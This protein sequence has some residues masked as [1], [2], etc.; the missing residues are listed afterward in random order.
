MGI[1]EIHNKLSV[2]L[3][4]LVVFLI[5]LTGCHSY[6]LDDA[7]T[8]LRSSFADGEFKESAHL[9][10]TFED[11]E[12]YRSNDEV[13]WNL[14][15]GMVAHFN[16]DFDASTRYL[17]RAEEQIDDAFTKSISR[18]VY[19]MVSN[20]NVLVYDG[21]PYED[22]Y[23]NAF[24]ALN[25]IHQKNWEGALVETRR[26]AYKMEQLDIRIKGIAEA[27]ARA[28]TTG[29][30]SWESGN[31]NIQN[32]AMSHYLAAILYAKSGRP[33]DSRI[34]FEKLGIA[35][36]E[37]AQLSGYS[38]FDIS[39]MESI[40]RP[41]SYNLLIA[42]FTGQ[43]PLKYQVDVRL[44][45]DLSEG[46]YLKFSFPGIRLYPTKVNAVRAVVNDS[47]E[48]PL[49]LVEEMDLVAQEVYK[50]KEPV[51][52]SRALLRA[53]LKAG[54]TNFVQNMAKEKSE[55]A[56]FITSLLSVLFKEA[57]EKADL[58]GWQTLPGQ[59]WMNVI[60]LPEG[61]NTVRLEYLSQQNKV[62]YFE[63]Y[64]VEMNSKTSLELIESIYSK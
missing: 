42:G 58:R 26:M 6:M 56:G 27:F 22:I 13:L 16:G 48:I 18:G 49:H 29:K 20:D 63:E 25:F 47:L 2:N 55:T 38:P 7:Q 11:K 30:V 62:L 3:L 37:Q 21:E 54:G 14:E 61:P 33:D 31:V 35:L 34:E 43:A 40:T 52:Y 60:E 5:S 36:Q 19:S 1:P 57:S 51:I 44:I 9:L 8:D 12:L 17:S 41:G 59:S 53:L 64:Q 28:D 15:N 10:S 32:S 4:F 24:K 45:N 39:N 46:R 23:V 50:A